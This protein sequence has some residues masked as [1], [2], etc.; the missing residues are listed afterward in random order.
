MSEDTNTIFDVAM[1][2]AGAAGLAAALAIAREGIPTALIGRHAPVADGRTVALLD[3]SVRFLE[4]L[5]A[6][7]AVAPQASPLCT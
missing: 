7:E 1:V 2:G 6:W 3:G 5:G 4:A